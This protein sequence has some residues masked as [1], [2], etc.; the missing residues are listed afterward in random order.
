MGL[1]NETHLVNS[2]DQQELNRVL[3]LIQAKYDRAINNVQ[4][5]AVDNSTS[6]KNISERV[7]N[8]ETTINNITL[9]DI[10]SDD[11]IS[12][13]EKP[14]FVKIYNEAIS[15]HDSLVAT[16][17][18]YGIVSELK[19][20]TDSYTTLTTFVLALDPAYNDYTKDTYLGEGGG[21]KLL[22][23]FNDIYKYR[24]QLRQ[25]IDAVVK[26]YFD[27]I[28]SDDKLTP[29]DK[30]QV[31]SM[32]Q[33]I[34]QVQNQIWAT[35]AQLYQGST[36]DQ[37]LSMAGNRTLK[38]YNDL[39]AD[40]ESSNNYGLG[41][42]PENK[43]DK[44]WCNATQDP[45]NSPHYNGQYAPTFLNWDYGW[46]DAHKQDT[47]DLGVGG[48]AKLRAK[49]LAIRGKSLLVNLNVA[50]INTI[51]GISSDATNLMSQWLL[52]AQFLVWD[53]T[54]GKYVLGKGTTI[55]NGYITTQMLAADTIFSKNLVVANF[56]NYIPNFS[57]EMPYKATDVSVP[58]PNTLLDS[59]DYEARGLVTDAQNSRSGTHCRVISPGKELV[60]TKPIQ[61]ASDDNYYFEAWIKGGDPILNIKINDETT[62]S[63]FNPTSYLYAT[64][65][66]WNIS[67]TALN[68]QWKGETQSSLDTK[69][70][71]S[72]DDYYKLP[73]ISQRISDYDQ[74]VIRG[75]RPVTTTFEYYSNPTF[76][77]F[78]H[79]YNRAYREVVQYVDSSDYIDPNTQLVDPG[80]KW[81]TVKRAQL[82]TTALSFPQSTLQIGALPGYSVYP[83]ETDVPATPA[84]S[85]VY[86]KYNCT[87]TVVETNSKTL[88]F[89]THGLP[90]TAR[91]IQFV[92]KNNSP[93]YNMYVDDMYARKM[94]DARIICDGILEASKIITA[95]LRSILVSAMVIKTQ[96]YEQEWDDTLGEYYATTGAAMLSDTPR[97]MLVAEDGLKVGKHIIGEV[98]TEVN[99][100]QTSNLVG[101]IEG[102]KFNC[103][104][105]ESWSYVVD[106]NPETFRSVSGY[107][108]NWDWCNIS[109]RLDSWGLLSAN[110]STGSSL[111]QGTNAKINRNSVFD[112][113][114]GFLVITNFITGRNV[115]YNGVATGTL[116]FALSANTPIPSIGRT[117]TL[118]FDWGY[119]FWN[120]TVPNGSNVQFQYD[121]YNSANGRR[122]GS[123]TA[124]VA[125]P[126]VGPSWQTVNINISSLLNYRT[127]IAP[128]LPGNITL[129]IKMPKISTAQYYDY[130]PNP[131]F[132]AFDNFSLVM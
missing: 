74:T 1:S 39:I 89:I 16:A 118:T 112:F 4:V 103:E 62:P 54:L 63:M 120:N 36:P 69:F 42:W 87:T 64:D 100:F 98:F 8:N 104:R 91:T 72:I 124:Y 6:I 25:A 49:F 7:S 132:L 110:I 30:V 79:I 22:G 34:K 88:D 26:G 53:G 128:G 92:I 95:E 116:E 77:E 57:S 51:L 61:V 17:G 113:P 41:Y 71:V 78:S 96:V 3:Q 82:G 105:T 20:Y 99:R 5:G 12:R 86:R 121:V 68:D 73:K 80:F 122:I 123:Q 117:P 58:W 81:I 119:Y 131:Y 24:T 21:K 27:D 45:I 33:D 47:L 93:T 46:Y 32:Y 101:G 127:S 60:L 83:S 107:N 111:V 2:N 125:N 56:E 67:A 48:G 44:H 108:V 11:Y 126:T 31:A 55:G 50:Y 97:A 65:T 43:G 59:P 37:I 38:E 29:G 40:L 75:G 102:I 90:T 129:L 9:A 115:D 13:Q 84:D 114:D 23:Y 14:S 18:S 130:I 19:L 85:S 15:D 76:L 66:K 106:S 70:K 35:Y 52:A 10:L 109:N 94:L 28:F